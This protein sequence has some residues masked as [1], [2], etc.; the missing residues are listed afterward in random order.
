MPAFECPD[1]HAG[2]NLGGHTT[3]SDNDQDVEFDNAGSYFVV[4]GAL[5]RL[6]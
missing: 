4:V 3:T 1:P 2:M 5:V 6:S